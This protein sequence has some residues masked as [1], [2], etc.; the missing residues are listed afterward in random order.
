MGGVGPV[1]PKPNAWAVV[2]PCGC[3]SKYDDN[4]YIGSFPPPGGCLAHPR[5]PTPEIPPPPLPP[6]DLDDHPQESW[7]SVQKEIESR[8]DID[9]DHDRLSPNDDD[10]REFIRSLLNDLAQAKD[11]VTLLQT[12]N[13]RLLEDARKARREVEAAKSVAE[14]WAGRA[15]AL[16]AE[17]KR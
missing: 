11:H 12:D 13:N 2:A 5:T 4:G 14:V 15:L 10:L 3:E 1:L 6:R 17:A 7:S 9:T 8:P 16:E